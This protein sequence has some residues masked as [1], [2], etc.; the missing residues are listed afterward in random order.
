VSAP[1]IYILDPLSEVNAIKSAFP[2]A[3]ISQSLGAPPGVVVVHHPTINR[4]LGLSG[5]GYQ[6]VA[7]DLV[8]GKPVYTF[9]YTRAPIKVDAYDLLREIRSCNNLAL[10]FNEDLYLVLKKIASRKGFG[11]IRFTN[12]IDKNRRGMLVFAGGENVHADLEAVCNTVAYVSLLP[13]GWGHGRSFYDVVEMLEK[14]ELGISLVT[15]FYERYD[16]IVDAVKAAWRYARIEVSECVAK[17]IKALFEVKSLRDPGVDI[18]RLEFHFVT[19]SIYRYDFDVWFTTE[20]Y[21]AEDPRGSV[22]IKCAFDDDGLSINVY[23]DGLE[24]RD[25]YYSVYDETPIV[26]KSGEVIT[27]VKELAQRLCE[28]IDIMGGYKICYCGSCY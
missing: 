22:D 11:D 14:G 23:N 27:T 28:L 4:M 2:Q 7:K 10:V 25:R 19:L 18:N 12:F 24:I 26:S 6:V 17:G 15:F 1:R 20:Y 13:W 3:E 16:N 8:D 9:F 5:T 21:D